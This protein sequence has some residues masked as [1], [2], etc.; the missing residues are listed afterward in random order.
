MLSTAARNAERAKEPLQHIKSINTALE[1]PRWLQPQPRPTPWPSRPVVRVDG[2]VLLGEVRAEH[3]GPAA[4]STAQE[5]L[6][7]H[8][9]MVCGVSQAAVSR[10]RAQVRTEPPLLVPVQREPPVLED[11]LAANAADAPL[12]HGRP[13]RAQRLADFAHEPADV[14][15]VAC[16]RRLEER[17]VDHRLGHARGRGVVRRAVHCHADDV[18]GALAVADH[19]RRQVA[20]HSAQRFGEGLRVR[21]ASLAAGEQRDRVAGGLVPVHRDGV[22]APAHRLCELGLQ[23]GAA[24]GHLG[25]SEEE[26]QHRGHVGLDHAGALG[27]AHQPRTAGQLCRADLRVAVCGHDALRGR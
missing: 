20:A 16:D 4:T 2:H 3:H 17:A 23:R 24:T 22:E 25:V 9:S 19:L 5:N 26:A 7:I 11:D 15:V 14:G 21:A 1:T 13:C 12:G 18:L 27:K 8:H 10:R 6:H